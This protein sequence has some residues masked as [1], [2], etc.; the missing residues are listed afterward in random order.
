MNAKRA[1][2][3]G[4]FMGIGLIVTV[5]DY[6][7]LNVFAVALRQ[8]VVL[9]NSISAPFSGFVSYKLNKRVVFEDRMHGRRKTLLLYVTV[10]GVGILV[11]QNTLI[12]VFAG[13]FSDS[14]ASL[15]KPVFELMGLGELS[16]RTI[17]INA[18]KVLA[19]LFSAAWN[20]YML[21][22][23]VFVTQEEAEI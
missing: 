23:F 5:L 16:V 3:I 13:P 21:R 8:P 6:F 17:S 9:A 20:Y 1:Q 19:S 12:H 14:V 15:V 7:L 10:V 4:R 2:E 18:A 11:I 22:R